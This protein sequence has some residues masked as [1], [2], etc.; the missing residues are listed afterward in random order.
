MP[1]PKSARRSQHPLHTAPARH[2]A[3]SSPSGRRTSFDVASQLV[4]SVRSARR[5]IQPIS[6][7]NLA[8][9]SARSA[10]TTGSVR[11]TG[12]DDAQDS[13]DTQWSAAL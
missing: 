6:A 3:G 5:Q 2:S 4:S 12:L 11:T 7:S 10:R 9:G 13:A 8:A 1:S